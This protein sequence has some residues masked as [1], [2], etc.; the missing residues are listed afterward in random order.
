[1]E[2]IRPGD[3]IRVDAGNVI[4]VDGAVLSGEAE[5]EPGRHDGGI[6]SGFQTGRVRRLCRNHAGNGFP[7]HPGGR[8]RRPVPH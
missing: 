2:Q 1:M 3:K 6:G 8:R 4:P 5:V 7:R